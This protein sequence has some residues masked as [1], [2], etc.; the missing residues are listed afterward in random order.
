MIKSKCSKHFDYEDFY[1]CSDTWITTKVDNT[2]AQRRTVE[3]ISEL[4]TYVLDPIVEHFGSIKIT[5]GLCMP[6][7]EKQIKKKIKPQ[8]CPKLDQ[9]AGYEINQRGNRICSRDG[10]ACD[11]VIEGQN[12][13][14][15]AKWISLNC[16]FDSMYI[17]GDYNPI[18][19]SY[20]PTN[21]EQI[22][23]MNKHGNNRIPRVIQK[24]SL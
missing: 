11:F 13:R 21:K 9:H 18:H 10:F 6:A 2:P 5:Y 24:E 12:M 7:L 17:Y 20:A 4:A 15:V 16:S 8:I 14:S 23:I 3:A 22:V 1:Y 19:V